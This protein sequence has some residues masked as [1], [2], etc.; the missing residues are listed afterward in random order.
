ML[1]ISV[2]LEYLLYNEFS[3]HSSLIFWIQEKSTLQYSQ[4]LKREKGESLPKTEK[5]SSKSFKVRYPFVR[6]EKG[7]HIT[8]G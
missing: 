8:S 2:R 1:G 6:T 3:F 5:E 4:N 7:P